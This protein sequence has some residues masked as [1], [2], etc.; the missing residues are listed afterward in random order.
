VSL[1]CLAL[2]HAVLCILPLPRQITHRE[3][4][5]SW[6]YRIRPS[7]THEPFHAL[8][9]PAEQVG[10][11]RDIWARRGGELLFWGGERGLGRG[12]TAEET[13]GGVVVRGW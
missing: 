11:G 9:F 6:L 1:P 8:N 13:E 5:R 2:C 7:V 4:Q 10:W 3:Q 12:D